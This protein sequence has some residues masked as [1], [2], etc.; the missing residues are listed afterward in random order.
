MEPP[1]H[2]PASSVPIYSRYNQSSWGLRSRV[3]T[4]P[5]PGKLE[6]GNAKQDSALTAPA[7]RGG[8][9]QIPQLTLTWHGTC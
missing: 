7:R 2:G 4:L 1:P 6:L 3:L 5:R 8:Q 9:R